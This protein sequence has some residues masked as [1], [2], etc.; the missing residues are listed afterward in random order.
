MQDK[1][2]PA[3]HSTLRNDD[4]ETNKK[5][6]KKSTKTSFEQL[7]DEPTAERGPEK[8]KSK[9]YE[10]KPKKAGRKA[11][12]D[13]IKS[14]LKIKIKGVRKKISLDDEEMLKSKGNFRKCHYIRKEIFVRNVPKSNIDF[15]S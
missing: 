7:T 3:L 5:P 4:K 14:E 2:G 6:A 8:E 1:Q 11:S 10:S 9:D 15:S 12:F 13:K